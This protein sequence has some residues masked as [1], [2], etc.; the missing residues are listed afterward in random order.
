MARPGFELS[1]QK[2][3]PVTLT[4]LATLTRTYSPVFWITVRHDQIV[5]V[6]EQWMP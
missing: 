1:I 3:I 6:S 4:R 2:S 5:K